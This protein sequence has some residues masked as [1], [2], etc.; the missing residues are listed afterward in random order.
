M[1]KRIFKLFLYGVLILVPVA[2]F[3]GSDAGVGS[4]EADSIHLDWD[5]REFD[6]EQLR[7]YRATK[8]FQ[9][10]EKPAGELTLWQR[11]KMII[12]NFFSIL[13]KAGTTTT[14]GKILVYLL[15][16]YVI[17]YA[18]FKLLKIEP[19]IFF[20]SKKSQGL[21]FTILDEDIHEMDFDALINDAI[22]RNSY[23]EAIRY[24]YLFTLK[25]LA[26]RGQILWE[27]GKTNENY[28]KEL[29]GKPHQKQFSKLNYYFIYCWYGEFEINQALFEKI[30]ALYQ[31]FFTKIDAL[32]EA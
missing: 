14:L 10:V 12:Q 28:L 5:L 16:G 22:D 18:I 9:Y 20:S 6:Q 19:K 4:V 11:L 23:R 26:D 30:Q 7:E 17:L 21:S 29:E 3:S 15:F 24:Y 27:S 2:G 25:K 32:V 1:T 8:E 31:E 13:F